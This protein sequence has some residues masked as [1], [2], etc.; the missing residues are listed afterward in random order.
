MGAPGVSD[1]YGFCPNKEISQWPSGPV[2]RRPGRL[3]PAGLPISGR[4]FH[5]RPDL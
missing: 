3:N 2:G 1:M 5:P 4:G